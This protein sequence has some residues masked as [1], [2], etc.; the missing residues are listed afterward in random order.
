MKS[1]KAFD[2][3]YDEAYERT[4][5]RIYIYTLLGNICILISVV[6]GIITFTILG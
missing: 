5:K 6:V 4:V 2:K 3:S 1:K